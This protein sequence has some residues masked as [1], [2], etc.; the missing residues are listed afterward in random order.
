M[1]NVGEVDV[2]DGATSGLATPGFSEAVRKSLADALGAPLDRIFIP[3]NSDKYHDSQELQASDSSLARIFDIMRELNERGMTDPTVGSSTRNGRSLRDALDL[4]VA[5]IA[6]AAGETPVQYTELGPEPV[7]TGLI[8]RA[9]LDRGVDVRRY[10]GVDINPASCETMRQTVSP[11][12]GPAGF[13]YSQM[14]FEELGDA[15][16]RL[17]GVRNIV[18]MLGFEE[19]NE[20]PAVVNSMLERIM[21]PG[22]L[23]LSEMQL[24]S[25]CGWQHIYAFYQTD[26]MREFSQ[27]VLRRRHPGITDSDYGVFLV[28]VPLDPARPEQTVMAAV[29]AEIVHTGTSEAPEILVTNYCLKFTVQDYRR[30]REAA[31]SLKVLDE[32]SSGDGTVVFQISQRL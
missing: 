19:G 31:G 22:D 18:T 28:P 13:T 2:R 29:T 9:L 5:D 26:L 23:F 14:L 11:L 16:H 15:K 17:P 30:L 21:Q 3:A 10:H 8:V 25:E 20:H 7:K 27:L 1:Q 6:R 12:L 24:L 4:A 32:R